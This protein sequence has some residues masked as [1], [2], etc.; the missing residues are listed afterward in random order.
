[1][2]E[3]LTNISA[4]HWS[5]LGIGL[6]ILEALGTGGFLIGAALSAFV[7]A[8]T[9]IMMPELSWRTQLSL[10]SLLSVIFTVVYWFK[11]RNFNEKTDQPMLN[12]RASHFIG[13]QYTLQEAIINNQGRLKIGDTLWKLHCDQDLPAN[14]DIEVTKTDGMALWVSATK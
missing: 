3:W 4:W 5:A 1:M 9:F 14:T 2:I 11:F 13:K 8:L 6:L 7:T 10:F 12:D